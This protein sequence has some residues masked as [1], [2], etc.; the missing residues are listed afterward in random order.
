MVCQDSFSVHRML[1]SKA[2]HHQIRCARAC[3]VQKLDSARFNRENRVFVRDM[4]P[5]C[6]QVWIHFHFLS[7]PLLDE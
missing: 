6:V 4:L 2:L 3:T 1:A 5:E 7:S